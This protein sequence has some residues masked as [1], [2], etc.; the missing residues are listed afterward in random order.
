MTSQHTDPTP[1]TGGGIPVLQYWIEHTL[2][3]KGPQIWQYLTHNS[4]CLSCAWGTGGQKGGFTNEEGETLQRCARSVEAIASELQPSSPFR[5]FCITLNKSI[6]SSKPPLWVRLSASKW[7]YGGGGEPI[8]KKNKR[9]SI[10][11]VCMLRSI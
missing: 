7:V 9:S 10:F 11:V 5:E 8:Q 1:S 6:K 3:P 2:S 4:A